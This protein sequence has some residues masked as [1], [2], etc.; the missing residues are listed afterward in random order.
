MPILLA[1]LS[2]LLLAGSG[3]PWPD[4]SQDLEKLGGGEEDA[5]VVVGIED[6]GYLPDIPGATRNSLAWYQYLT[7]VRGV[8]GTRVFLLEN[9]EATASKIQRA[10]RDAAAKVRPGGTLWFVFIGHGAPNQDGTDGVLVAVD[11]HADEMDFFP[12]TV[13]RS[14]LLRTLGEA[15]AVARVAILDA[16]FSGLESGGRQ[17]VEGRQFAVPASLEA[18]G[19]V[20]VLTAG[21]SK[22]YAG[23]LPGAKRPAFSYLVLGAL[24]G[25]GDADGDKRVTASE[26][27]GYARDVLR[28]L[29]GGRRQEPQLS[30]DDWALTVRHH[31]ASAGPD[32]VKVREQLRGGHAAS[33][34]ITAPPPPVTGGTGPAIESGTATAAVADVAILAEPKKLVRLEVTPPKGKKV[35]S[36]SPYKNWSGE[37]GKWTVKAQAS[38]YED[39]ESTF[40]APGDD[41]T[42]HRIELK[43]LGGLEVSGTPTSAS[44]TVTGPGGF[45]HSGA[46]TWTA[47]SL[48]SGMYRVKVSREGYQDV[49]K[50]VEV[51]PGK[52]TRL[53]V[54]LEKLVAAITGTHP[55]TSGTAGL[56]WVYSKPAG[57]SFAR[58]ET[59]VAQYRAC[60]EAG[61]CEP[62]HHTDKSDFENCNWG[63]GD[64]DDH[65]MNCVDWYGADQFCRWAGGRLPTE[66]EW[67]AETGAGGARKYPWGSDEPSCSRC[68]MDDGG[69]GCGEGHTW[70]VCS[71]RR[72]DSVSGLC[73]MAGNVWEWTSS[74][75]NSKKK[76]RVLRGGSWRLDF[77]EYLSAS[78]RLGSGPVYWFNDFGFRCVRSSQ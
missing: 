42:V 27:V 74:W 6:Y 48:K 24:Q 41:V 40:H 66:Q 17:L 53:P 5:A 62:K 1:T 26:V 55:T 69:T 68:V 49:S 73:D 21:R 54:E 47:N 33:E 20:T 34:G 46:L 56:E 44:V 11:A 25:W 4:L 51:R 9:A 59:T 16:C 64:R 76:S 37:P 38:G 29:D 32:L 22:D 28:V 3:D 14:E 65:P 67:E 45:S 30:G 52:K 70:P 12:R 31:R 43:E 71:K 7:K 15:K 19:D 39:Y 36:G 75:R 58:S 57:I 18:V 72:G 13:N 63:C 8:P 2:L 35:V 50:S 77:T 60:V 78:S 61:N 23:P 10:V